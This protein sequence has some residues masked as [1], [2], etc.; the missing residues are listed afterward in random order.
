[1]TLFHTHVVDSVPVAVSGGKGTNEFLGKA[2]AQIAPVKGNVS[3][4]KATNAPYTHRVGNVGDT[5]LRFIGA[6][7]KTASEFPGVPAVLDS[8]VGHKLMLENDRVKVYRVSIDPKQI[9]GLRARTLPWLR[10]TVSP[11]TI[12]VN[13]LRKNPEIVETKSGDFRW[14]EGATNQSIENI[15]S[16]PYEAIE[17]EW[18]TVTPT[19]G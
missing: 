18:K 19:R 14:H 3:F 1:M 9:T 5:P 4:A 6:E 17:I 16:T 11:S 2:P 15:G 12:S 13:A 10:I 7:V 8:V